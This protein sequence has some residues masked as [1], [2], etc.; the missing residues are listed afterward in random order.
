ML[1]RT[2][3][4]LD[5]R[6]CDAEACT[7]LPKTSQGKD[8]DRVSESVHQSGFSHKFVPFL[9]LVS[10]TRG[11]MT[12]HLLTDMVASARDGQVQIDCR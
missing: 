11:I 5:A 12:R 9:D 2:F 1:D 3:I 8:M 7:A 6:V 10:P 4:Q